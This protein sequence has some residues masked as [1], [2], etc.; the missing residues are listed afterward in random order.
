MLKEFLRL[1]QLSIMDPKQGAS[2]VL[3]IAPNDRVLAEFTVL[4]AVLAGLT[5]QPLLTGG[6]DPSG[7]GFG[8]SFGPFIATLLQGG[9][10]VVFS[11]AT[12]LI[13]KAFGGRGDFRGAVLVVV[14]IQLIMLIVQMFLVL[15][16]SFLPVS[17]ALLTLGSLMLFFW[18]FSNFVAVLH[19]FRSAMVVLA[20]SIVSMFVIIFA[21]AALL[22]IFVPIQVN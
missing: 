9:M 18:L 7:G 5:A 14:W 1:A 11:L 4:V 12:F 17:G 6:G 13:G 20:T 10:L 19:A 2:Q 15:V 3:G 21:V 16:T 8:I 22:P